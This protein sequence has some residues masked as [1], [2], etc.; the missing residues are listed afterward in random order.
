MS[1]QPFPDFEPSVRPEEFFD[2][3]LEKIPDQVYFKDRQGRFLRAS[4]AVADYLDVADPDELIGKSDFDFWSKDT[5]REAAEDERRIMETGKPMVGKVERL[6]HPDGRVT[7]D[8]TT[9]MPLL[10]SNGNVIGICGINKDFTAMKE[11]QD[12]LAEERNR[13]KATTEELA[14]KNAALHADLQLAREVQEALLPR[15]YPTFPGFGV[16]GQN[17]LS[18]AHC[19]LP[20]AAVGGD[21]FDIFPLS[22]T[23]AGVLVCDVMGHGL[24]AALIM[25]I[26]RALLEELRPMMHQAGRFL[27]SL[28]LRLRA[29]LERVEE[30]FVA[31]AFYMIADTATK[32]VSFANAGHPGPCRICRKAGT[33]EPL[34]TAREQNGPALGIFDSALFPTS[35]APFEEGDCIVIYTDGIFEVFSPEGREFGREALMSTFL[36]NAKLPANE[37]FNAVLNEA[38]SFSSRSDFDDDVC[39]VAVE[40]AHD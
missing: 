24:R 10:D 22:K 21:F 28:N 6:V 29:L 11:M 12:A 25:A 5:A 15:D 27:E 14:A 4:R 9:K 13:L 38:L 34:S 16:S 30:P 3:L 26:I 1:S 33:A 18:F 39:L 2:F 32:E 31:T 36:K 20:A 8:Y 37:L 7:W 40:R 17:A 23:R 19:Y 35:R